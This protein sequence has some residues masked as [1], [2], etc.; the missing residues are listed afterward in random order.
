M[1]ANIYRLR[2]LPEVVHGSLGVFKWCEN[3]NIIG[4]YWLNTLSIS[5]ICQFL[6]VSLQNDRFYYNTSIHYMNIFCFYQ[7]LISHTLPDPACWSASSH[8]THAICYHA[9]WILLPSPHSPPRSIRSVQNVL[10]TQ[11]VNFSEFTKLK[12]MKKGKWILQRRKSTCIKTLRK[13]RSILSCGDITRN[14]CQ[15]KSVRI[16]KIKLLIRVS[17]FSHLLK[18][19][20][21]GDEP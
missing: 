1:H 8:Q 4:L 2:A 18:E 10:G 15:L 5:L 7:P 14:F 11:Q 9:L 19:P 21:R 16:C 13:V 20:V 17:Q 3:R 6:K 12:K